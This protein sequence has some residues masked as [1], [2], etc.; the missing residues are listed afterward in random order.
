MTTATPSA[1]AASSPAGAAAEPAT[2]PPPASMWA[3]LQPHIRKYRWL[4]ILA[5]FLNAFHGLGVTI[6]NLAPKYLIDDI[7]LAP[8]ITNHQRYVRLLWLCLAYLG[9]SL[10]WRMLVWHLGYRIF[11][12]VR[13]RI[14]FSL[15]ADFFRHVNHLCLR[16]HLKHHSG[17]LFS[18]LFGS[19]LNQIQTYF[20]QWTF[21]V[22]GAICLLVSTL[23]WIGTWDW[24]LTAI[25]MLL[26]IVNVILMHHIRP[27]LQVLNSA[28]QST[29]S[30][31]SGYVA[32]LLRGSR[33]IKLYAMEDQVVADFR[34]RVWLIGQ[35]AYRRDIQTHVQ[36]MK[37][38]TAGYICFT[39]LC[40]ACA[41]RY[42]HDQSLPAGQHRISIGEVQAYLTNFIAMQWPI[43]AMFSVAAQRGAAQAGLDR[44]TAVLRT[45]STTPDPV[46]YVSD[47]PARGP[48]QLFDVSFAYHADTPVLKHITLEIPYGQKVALVGPSGAG[49]STLAQ[50]ILRLYD[51]DQGAI[52]IGGLNLRHCIGQDL[53]RHFAV[54]PQDPFI[55]RTTIRHNLSVA[56]PNATEEEMRHA[57][58]QA[59]AWEF[60]SVLPKGLDEPVGEGGAT[61]SGGQRQRLA[62]ARALLAEQDFF[63]FDE[64]TSALDT[65]S[66]RLIQEALHEAMKNRTAIV[67]AHRLATV[68]SCDRILVVRD[69]EIVQDGSYDALV[70]IPGLFR[71][72]VH[73]QMLKA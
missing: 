26:V 24:M 64:A 5:L 14:V 61:L 45:D 67:I 10:I 36:G 69:G 68:K 62:I 63:I 39:L 3:F 37:S 47:L 51:P 4:I 7:I 73:G 48:I 20:Q 19:P 11:T 43:N 9:A 23:I 21:Q 57:C 55:F 34:D 66:E 25:L 28:F 42:I 70:A 46:G 1:A 8:G 38:E 71:E 16:F 52:L 33:D 50:L 30:N 32:D 27:R 41:W 53:R 54:V 12:Y 49:K 2:A 59:N 40:A 72:L 13:E 15:R 31:V 17:E 29:E 60:I 56:R 44:L 22:P 58:Q 65:V 35:Q 6:Q 18:Y